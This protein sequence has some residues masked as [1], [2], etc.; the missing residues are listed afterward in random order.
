MKFFLALFGVATLLSCGQGSESDNQ[1]IQGIL[2]KLKTNQAIIN[3]SIDNKQFYADTTIFV[4]NGVVDEKGIKVSLMDKDFGNVIVSIEGDTWYKAKPYMVEFK[5]GY[6][7][8]SNMGSFLVG[9]ITSLKENKGEGYLLSDG[10]FEI[11]YL[12]KEVMVVNV[13]GSLKQ[14][15]GNSTL[16]PIEGYIIWKVPGY[17]FESINEIAIPFNDEK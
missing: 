17:S 8:G 15:F 12:S 9:K 16:S 11:K 5:N 7:T 4:G 2:D 1:K 10:F 3:L 13:R 6:P 14:P